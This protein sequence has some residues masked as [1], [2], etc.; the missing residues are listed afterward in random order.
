M[1]PALLV[2][3]GLVVAASSRE[4]AVR[5]RRMR[6][7]ASRGTSAL[8]RTQPFEPV[9]FLGAEPVHFERGAILVSNHQ[10]AVDI[11]LVLALPGDVR[12]TLKKRVWDEPWF[13]IAA[14]RLGH[15]LIEPDRPEVTLERC[16]R[17]ISEGS[18]VHFFP[19]GTRTREA[20]PRR[21]HRGAFDVAVEL[22]CDVL[23]VVIAE[24]RRAVPDALWIDD[25][26]LSV[27]VQPRITP[28]EFDHAQGPRALAKHVQELVRAELAREM[29]RLRTPRVLAEDVRRRYRYLGREVERAVDRA[30]AAELDG[31]GPLAALD[32]ALPRV[33]R[34]LDLA[35]GLGMRAHWLLETAPR[36]SVV[37]VEPEAAPRRTAERRCAQHGAPHR[38]GG[39]GRSG[40]SD[41]CRGGR[42]RT[43]SAARAPDARRGRPRRAPPGARSCSPSRTRGPRPSS[44]RSSSPL[45]SPA[46]RAWRVSTAASRGTE[47]ARASRRRARPAR[48]AGSRRAARARRSGT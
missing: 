38:A 48:A 35:C 41:D 16:R 40:R 46:P 28:A 17:A 10:S 42:P 4:P 26:R 43:L 2:G 47:C 39:G 12:L 37:A 23:P 9:E 18:L 22:G 24:S 7:W 21:F 5:A 34:L 44:S 19:E 3:V 33:G 30:V 11:G 13:G 8:L 29:E 20:W 31:R 1:Q 27:R 32:A 15:V 45:A 36:R 25:Y 14:R 6:R